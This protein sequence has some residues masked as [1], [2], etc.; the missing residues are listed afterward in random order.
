MLVSLAVLGLIAGLTV[1]SI[2]VSVD[3]SK[4]RAILKEAFQIVSAITQAGVLNGDFASITDWDI[5]NSTNPQGI[6][7]YLTSKLNYSKQCLTGDTTSVGCTYKLLG[8]PPTGPHNNH[9]ARWILPNGAKIQAQ[10]TGYFFHGNHHLLWLITSKPDGNMQ[11]QG[12]N[13]DTLLVTCNIKEQTITT[14]GSEIKSGM[15]GPWDNGIWR[16]SLNAVLGLT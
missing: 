8:Y 6:V 16:N 5:V 15:C 2:V 14:N 13:P 3:R 4:N 10:H 1:P 7:G 11:Y 9:N 12:S